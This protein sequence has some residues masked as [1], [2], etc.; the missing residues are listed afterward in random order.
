[1]LAVLFLSALLSPSRARDWED[2][3]RADITCCNPNDNA[4]ICTETTGGAGC[5]W[6]EYGLSDDVDQII[7]QS[8]SQCVGAE[9][10]RCRMET[11]GCCA[12]GC[13][14]DSNDPASAPAVAPTDEPAEQICGRGDPMP[15]CVL[16][17]NYAFEGVP[18]Q[19]SG[20]PHTKMWNGGHHDFQGQPDTYTADGTLKNQFYY[21]APCSD[22]SSVDL[23]VTILGTH[24][25][26]RTA[27]VSGLD[28]LVLELYD[29]LRAKKPSYNIYLSS[30][31]A[32]Y[33]DRSEDGVTTD[34]D[35]TKADAPHAL[36]ALESGATTAI[37]DRFSVAFTD[38]GDSV[39]LELT[40][41][42]VNN[43]TI[44]MKAMMSEQTV[45]SGETRYTM[46]YTLIQQ[47]EAYKCASCGLCGNFKDKVDFTAETQELERCD[48]SMV[49][50]N[51][52]DDE[53]VPEAYDPEGW[54]WEKNFVENECASA[55]SSTI[56]YDIADNNGD[57]FVFVASCDE[58]IQTMVDTKCEGSR[59]KLTQC[60]NTMG[61]MCDALLSDCKSDVCVMATIEGSGDRDLIQPAI[62]A[63]LVAAIEAACA[64]PGIEGAFDGANIVSF[65]HVGCWADDEDSRAIEVMRQGLDDIEDCLDYCLDYEFFGVIDVRNSNLM[66]FCTNSESEYQ[67][68]GESDICNNGAG[69]QD[70]TVI[71]DSETRTRERIVE[72]AMDVYKITVESLTGGSD[73]EAVVK[74]DIDVAMLG[75]FQRDIKHLE[76]AWQAL[77]AQIDEH[78]D[79]IRGEDR[80]AEEELLDEGV[81]DH[82]DH[83][84]G[85]DR[86]D[87]ENLAEFIEDHIREEYALELFDVAADEHPDHIRGENWEGEEE[88]VEL[89]EAKDTIDEHPDHIRGEDWAG[90]E[91]ALELF[92]VDADE[93]PDHIRG[94]DR[95]AEEELLDERVDE[96]PDHVR[97]EDW[98]DEELI[99]LVG[100]PKTVDEHPDHIRG[101]DWEGEELM[102]LF[103][104]PKT[105]DGHP[106]HIRGQ[107]WAGEEDALELFEVAAD[108]HPDHIRGEDH[109]AEEELVDE[110]VDEHPEHIRG[111]DREE[112]AIDVE[113]LEASQQNLEVV[114]ANDTRWS[115]EPKA[116]QL[117]LLMSLL[118]LA[119]I[120][121]AVG[122]Y[123]QWSSRKQYTN[124][125]EKASTA[126]YGTNNV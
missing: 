95:V 106:D 27:L 55:G 39:T 65:E 30:A 117:W 114:R 34:Y 100:E 109:A 60:C 102:S 70:I 57:D 42:G 76:P 40:V 22:M 118:S 113:M 18:C 91:D 87:A 10:Y 2:I 7:T 21:I 11:G 49:A 29:T 124:I 56:Q 86:E 26:Y 96:H 121:C 37:G 93:H 61:D 62:D 123:R 25:R 99:A 41:D 125:A 72:V 48:G 111:E 116:G 53:S 52:G 15:N 77:E 20:D 78:P 66:C 12:P 36:N 4:D 38:D 80:V 46:H 44:F 112:E 120:I 54:T 98:E 89:F 81:D 35:D 58:K 73:S 8:G 108:E 16:G 17:L 75:E 67:Q 94:Q 88:L 51:A 9:Y 119:M 83:I 97:G 74:A 14:D 24:L 85:Q 68:Y 84:R 31:I 13:D 64:F 63:T 103:D 122:A 59:N 6:L 92:E 90:E 105:L 50:F 101:E 43:I 45:S 33:A 47:A 32:S 69:G 110:G 79:H 107:D 115:N 126:T 1:M 28:Y 5:V 104:E 71:K 23:P 82:P 19:I 3:L